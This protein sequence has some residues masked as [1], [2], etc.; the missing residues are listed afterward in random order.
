MSERSKAVC[1]ILLGC[2]FSTYARAEGPDAGPPAAAEDA[3]AAKTP[4]VVIEE[5]DNKSE[6][7]IPLPV[8]EEKRAIGEYIQSHSEGVRDC[9]SDRVRS[10]PTLQGK[11]IARFQIGPNGRVIGAIAEGIV[12]PVLLACVVAEVRKWEF[13][14]PASGGKL[15]V[16]YPYVFK[17]I[18]N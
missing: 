15:R 3:G 6:A 14:K 16:N 17:P 1:L 8:G 18:G 13:D 7:P 9:Y 10:K 5:T 11:L 2:L 4:S 12:D